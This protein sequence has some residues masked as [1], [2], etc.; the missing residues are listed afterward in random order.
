MPAM[1]TVSLG[2]VK[3]GP[4]RTRLGTIMKPAAAAAD[5]FRKLRRVL[6]LMAEF[7][8]S[9]EVETDCPLEIDSIF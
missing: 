5:V 9:L 6:P 8:S 3:P 4:P 2:A 7:V 1:F